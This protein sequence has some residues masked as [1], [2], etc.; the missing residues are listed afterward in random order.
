MDFWTRTVNA[1]TG[2]GRAPQIAALLLVHT[3]QEASRSLSTWCRG[4]GEQGTLFLPLEQ[5]S[6]M[7]SRLPTPTEAY[8]LQVPSPGRHIF[9]NRPFLWLSCSTRTLL[10]THC[11]AHARL[12]LT[13][14]SPSFCLIK[15][16]PKPLGP[17]II[18]VHLHL[19]GKGLHL[20]F[21][22]YFF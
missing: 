21:Y 2:P 11:H 6:G 16:M 8:C 10:C 20:K 22:L 5:K 19:Y 4:R 7:G 9:K 13:P 15:S 18:L 14:P 1:E 3:D 17:C 12:M